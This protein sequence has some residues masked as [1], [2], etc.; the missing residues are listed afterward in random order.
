MLHVNPNITERFSINRMGLL[1]FLRKNKQESRSDSTFQSRA[2]EDS[3]AVRNRGKRKF[4]RIT[5]AALS[6]VL[7]D[8]VPDELPESD[9][10]SNDDSAGRE[11]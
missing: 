4:K 3:D 9:G 2:E 7:P 6:D 1:S 10:D 8:S 11:P 5:G